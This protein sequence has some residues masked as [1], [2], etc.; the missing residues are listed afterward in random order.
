MLNVSTFDESRLIRRNK[1]WDDFA[2][3]G[4]ENLGDNF[5]GEVEEANGSEVGQG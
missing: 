4:G 3:P 1:V 2:K 5:V